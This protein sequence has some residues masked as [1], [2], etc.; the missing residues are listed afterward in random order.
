MKATYTRLQNND[1]GILC[2]ERPN[3]GDTITVTK[4]DGGTKNEIVAQV[5][6][7]KGNFACAIQTAQGGAC[8][9]CGRHS[10]HRTKRY[11][12][13]GIEGMVCELCNRESK[14][15]LSFA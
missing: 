14:Y 11:D 4:R 7:R 9:N 15:T 2:D 3:V 5:F 10:N 12:S 8:A 13:S 1:W 6:T